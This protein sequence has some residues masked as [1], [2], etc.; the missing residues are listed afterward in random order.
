[1]EEPGRLQSMGSL[2]VIYDWATSLHFSLSCTG[3]GSGTP[4]QYILAWRIP[5][6]GEP[7][8]LPSLGSHRVEHDWSDT[9]A[10]VKSRF[11]DTNLSVFNFSSFDGYVVVFSCAFNL[12]FTHDWGVWTLLICLVTICTFYCVKSP[13]VFI[14]LSLYYWLILESIYSAH[15]SSVRSLLMSV[16][17]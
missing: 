16:R 12:H 1:M 13:Q 14:V 9:A 3:E 11:G 6:M 5:G 7:G 17:I 2:R 4:L 8:G 15:K 10:A